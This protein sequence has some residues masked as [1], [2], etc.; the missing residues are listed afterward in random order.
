M[1]RYN[2]Y[3]LKFL[4]CFLEINFIMAKSK[5]V[6]TISGTPEVKGRRNEIIE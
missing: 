1:I 4:H 3:K 6:Y 2:K 5:E